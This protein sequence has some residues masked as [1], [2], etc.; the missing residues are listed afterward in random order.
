[1]NKKKN[2]IMKMVN[3]R[4]TEPQHE[5]IRRYAF[6]TNQSIAE[7]IRELLERKRLIPPTVE[8]IS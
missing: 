2:P 7:I 5:A 4:M 3:I 1:M 6:D 8:N